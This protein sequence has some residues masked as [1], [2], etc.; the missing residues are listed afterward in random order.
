[1]HDVA[2][3][4]ETARKAALRAG[5]TLI[6]LSVVLVLIGFIVGG[7][8]VGQ[9][10]IRAAALRAQI[11]QIERFNTATNTFRAKY[12]YLPGDMPDPPATGLGFQPRGLYAGEGDGNGVI[13][14]V[15]TNAA[16]ENT[17]KCEGLGESVM[18]WADLSTASL[19]EGSF[20]TASPTLPTCENLGTWNQCFPDA[21]IGNS[22]SVFVWSTSQ[23]A[24]SFGLNNYFGIEHITLNQGPQMIGNP[25][26]TVQQAYA[27]DTKVD[28]GLPMSG[29]VL[30]NYNADGPAW[31][32]GQSGGFT[33]F[34]TATAGSATS[35]FDNSAASGG[36]PGVAGATQHYSMEMNNGTGAN[37]ALSFQFQ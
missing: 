36:S 35:C 8:L 5:F 34:T 7:V 16:N 37:C 24:S 18:F 4:D 11:T 1:M 30:A 31:S 19:I 33:P 20:T 17:G 29:R 28:D 3:P 9:D 10:L 21:K 14:G 6:E 23:M 26:L 25:A 13:E 2:P 27:I 12:G 32:G 22:N 15:V